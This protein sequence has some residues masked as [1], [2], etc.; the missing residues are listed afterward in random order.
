MDGN[1]RK[2]ERK[3]TGFFVFVFS[4]PQREPRT[5]NSG[6]WTLAQQA[7]CRQKALQ[8]LERGQVIQTRAGC[9]RQQQKLQT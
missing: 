2:G 6:P 7:G 1:M 4:P 5:G 3:I 9:Q 8:G